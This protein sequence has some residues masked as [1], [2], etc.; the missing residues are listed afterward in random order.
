MLSFKKGF[1]SPNRE[2]LRVSALWENGGSIFQRE[3]SK[4]FHADETGEFCVSAYGE[5]Y[6][7]INE[8]TSFSVNQT[9]TLEAGEYSILVHIF[10]A[11]GLPCI[12]VKDDTVV[13]NE[14][15]RADC[16]SRIVLF[17]RNGEQLYDG[18][19]ESF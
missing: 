4:K 12:F 17:L 13:S 5:G 3:I 7:L 1:I 2:K 9:I 8:Q 6:V 11:N 16:F 15:W 14:S 19:M 10:N 18:A